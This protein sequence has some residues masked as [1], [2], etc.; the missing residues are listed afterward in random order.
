MQGPRSLKSK[1]GE[2]S[3]GSCA[4]TAKLRAGAYPSRESGEG[5]NEQSTGHITAD[6]GSGAMEG[7]QISFERR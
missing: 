1:N 7:A 4:A 2:E 6:A 3:V 5:C